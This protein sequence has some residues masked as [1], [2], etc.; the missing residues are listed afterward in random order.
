[1][2]LDDLLHF[3]PINFERVENLVSNLSV[4]LQKNG[5]IIALFLLSRARRTR[6]YHKGQRLER[7][8]VS[9]SLRDVP[10]KI[11]VTVRELRSVLCAFETSG[12]TT[13]KATQPNTV[14]SILNFNTYVI[15]GMKSD[16]FPATEATQGRHSPILEE[17][18]NVVNG[19]DVLP[20]NIIKN[21]N[22]DIIPR[23][24][25]E[26]DRQPKDDF[27]KNF[28]EHWHEWAGDLEPV[29]WRQLDLWR[30]TVGDQVVLCA[31]LHVASSGQP[32]S[33]PVAYLPSLFASAKA[34]LLKTQ[35]WHPLCRDDPLY[36]VPGVVP[37]G[38]GPGG[39]GRAH[40]NGLEQVPSGQPRSR[41]ASEIMAEL[42]AEPDADLS[43]DCLNG[44]NRV[45]GHHEP[46]LKC[47][48]GR[49]H[50]AKR[51]KGRA[52]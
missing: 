5:Y 3:T 9:F 30:R 40:G 7:G 33:D 18:V 27:E 42:M 2:T 26:E 29:H 46:C 14:L 21:A 4:C 12:F 23:V 8:D 22:R 32:K 31:V 45:G 11:P 37:G 15:D 19:E 13:Q 10:R 34:G 17:V 51:L 41:L 16:T 50:A 47:E 25:K 44:F 38:G 39:N 49:Y 20:A 48:R 28:V 24:P 36:R 1:M 6:G 35:E 52:L 43:C